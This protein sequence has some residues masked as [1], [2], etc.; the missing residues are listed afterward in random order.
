MIIVKLFNQGFSCASVS[1]SRIAKS[2][3]MSIEL[4]FQHFHM[5]TLDDFTCDYY[6]ESGKN[7]KN[8]HE[9]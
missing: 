9:K 7:S 1:D 2:L 8:V 3:Y 5:E 6:V 4:S